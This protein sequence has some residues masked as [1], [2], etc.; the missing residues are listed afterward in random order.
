MEIEITLEVEMVMQIDLEMEL[1]M[2]AS[3]SIY[4]NLSINT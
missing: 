4:Q 2:V 1:W 3:S